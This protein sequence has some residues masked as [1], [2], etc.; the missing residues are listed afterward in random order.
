MKIVYFTRDLLFPSKAQHAARMGGVT[1]QL[2]GSPQQCAD[3]VDDDTHRVVVDLGSTSEPLADLAAALLAKKPE[4]DLIAY[5][6]HVQTDRLADAKSAGFRT[7]SNGQV[8]S[9]M[10]VVFGE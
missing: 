4:L 5:G 9:G 2:V 3:A 10:N 7:M 1:L 6:P 8:H